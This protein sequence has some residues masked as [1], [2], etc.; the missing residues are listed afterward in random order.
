M[1][2]GGNLGVA[3]VP[4]LGVVAIGLLEKHSKTLKKIPRMEFVMHVFEYLLEIFK[5]GRI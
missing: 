1:K 5:R 3:L 4:T 2:H